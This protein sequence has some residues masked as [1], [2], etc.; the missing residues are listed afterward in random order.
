M[1]V[2]CLLSK[3]PPVIKSRSLTQPAKLDRAGGDLSGAGRGVEGVMCVYVCVSLSVS[4]PFFLPHLP[5]VTLC[6]CVCVCVCFVV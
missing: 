3:L 4:L 6:V 1:L 5:H 2:K